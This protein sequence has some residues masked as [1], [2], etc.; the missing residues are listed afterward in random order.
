MAESLHQYQ[1]YVIAISESG[2]SIYDSIE[3][4]D[5][6]LWIPTSALEALLDQGL[7]GIS[8]QGLPIRTRSKVVKQAICH[9]L[10]YPVP[11]TFKKTHPKFVGQ[12]FDTYV[13]KSNNFQIWNEEIVPTQ[14]YVIIRV[15]PHNVIEHVKVVTGEELVSL[16]TTGTLT[17]KYQARIVPGQKFTE[18]VTG[19]DTANLKL[20]IKDSDQHVSFQHSPVDD[21]LPE[22]LLPIAAIFERLRSLV[23][24]T[25]A[26]AGYDQDR[27]RGA[28]LQRLVCSKLGYQEYRDA[29]SFPDIRNQLLEIKLQTSPTIDLGLVCPD[30]QELLNLPRIGGRQI[31]HCD[32]RYA[33]FY[34]RTDGEQVE[35]THFYLT[36]G[37]AFFSR[38]PQ[39]QGKV[40]NKKL[41]IPLPNDFFD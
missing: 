24:R 28:E 38:F 41:Q 27:N 31:R 25:F 36:T 9:V 16:D 5:P 17:R 21:P 23:G 15:S 35:L 18:L 2:L 22:T 19:E 14:R 32:V 26:D 40:V 12:R 8:V 11:K 37:E 33:I 30:S 4:Q 34:A 39:F 13:Q 7:K 20:V 6:D 29:G 3:V 1:K 10:G